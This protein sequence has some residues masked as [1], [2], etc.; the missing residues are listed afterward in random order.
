[1]TFFAAD[2]APLRL[3]RFRRNAEHGGKFCINLLSFCD[4]VFDACDLM[5]DVW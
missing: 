2:R 5:V 3:P 1:M 4:E